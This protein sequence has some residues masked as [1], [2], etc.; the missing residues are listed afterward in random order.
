M[1]IRVL[2]CSG[3]IGGSGRKTTSFLLGSDVLIDAGSGVGE[4]SLDELAAIRHI[5]I[6]HSHLDHIQML[7]LLLDSVF[8]RL[9]QPVVVHGLA[10]TLKALRDHIFNWVVWPDFTALPS[11][12]L[13]VLVMQPMAPGEQVTVGDTRFGMI[14][15]NH[16]VPTVAYTVEYPGG[17][18]AFSGDTTTNDTLWE[19]LNALDRLDHLIVEA[20]FSSG[21][22]ALCEMSKHYCPQLLAADLQKLR[23]HP[24]IYL[25]HAKPGEEEM[26]YHE[27]QELINDRPLCH[28]TGGERLAL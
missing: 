3:G 7:P 16:I 6:T 25:S 24:R 20:A 19:G 18:F 12:A 17:V 28:L 26:I 22:L 9:E 2:G 27:C 21:E 10:H 4:L 8:D 23:H 15:V 13:P 14:P 5:F 1:E 11:E